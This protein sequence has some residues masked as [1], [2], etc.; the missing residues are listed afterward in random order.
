[1]YLSVLL[2]YYQYHLGTGGHTQKA[3]P[4]RGLY[5]KPRIHTLCVSKTKQSLFEGPEGSGD[6]T[7]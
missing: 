2:D 5:P 7:D 1:M 4:V 3:K 6:R